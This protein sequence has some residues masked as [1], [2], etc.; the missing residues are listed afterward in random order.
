[1]NS[2]HRQKVL[3]ERPEHAIDRNTRVGSRIVTAL[4]AIWQEAMTHGINPGD[5]SPTLFPKSDQQVKY[6]SIRARG[7]SNWESIRE[8]A[9]EEDRQYT[10][11]YRKTEGFIG[12]LRDICKEYLEIALPRLLEMVN[13]NEF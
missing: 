11:D 13:N 9:L 4:E 1:M 12:E 10:G 2:I 6:S 8:S 7:K 5:P 3:S